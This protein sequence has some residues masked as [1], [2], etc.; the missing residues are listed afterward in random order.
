MSDHPI[1]GRRTGTNEDVMESFLEGKPA[2]SRAAHVPGGRRMRSEGTIEEA[3]ATNLFSYQTVIARRHKEGDISVTP[4]RYST[5]TSKAQGKLQR[6]MIE[7][8]YE[9]SGESRKVR[10]KVPG[11]WGGFGPAWHETGWED[12]PFVHYRK[13]A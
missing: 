7:R 8:G 3:G 10:A 4:R 9:P 5:T 6:R 11:R 1:F 2:K 13:K 12:L